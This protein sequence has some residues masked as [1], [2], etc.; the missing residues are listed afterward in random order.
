MT[1]MD[2]WKP[3]VYEKVKEINPDVVV[4]DF[5]S[6]PG[7]IAADKLGIPSLMNI[8][9]PSAILEVFSMIEMPDMRRS[10]NCC[11]IICLKRS[12]A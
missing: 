3:Y 8:P 5:W 10:R 4:Y 7:A 12:V 2:A 1:I 9:G 11:G 6:K